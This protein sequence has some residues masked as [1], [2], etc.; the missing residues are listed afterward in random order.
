MTRLFSCSLAC[1]LTACLAAPA[2][3]L[4]PLPKYVE[5]HYAASPDYAKFVE[6]FKGLKMKCDTCHTR[7]ADKK[8]KG[9][10]LN[11]FGSAVHDHFQH[12]DF[13]AANKLAKDN[14]DEAAKAKKLVAEALLAAEAEK[15]AAGKTYGELLKAGQLPATK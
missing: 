10:G 7:G 4:P 15:N 8:A 11:D 1:L 6:T 3:A 5:E 14:P 12:R 2:F 13:L 9:H